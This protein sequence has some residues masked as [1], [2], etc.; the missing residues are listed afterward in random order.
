MK[1]SKAASESLSLLYI[2]IK[3]NLSTLG[4]S[5]TNAIVLPRTNFAKVKTRRMLQLT[6]F[7]L[8]CL[9]RWMMIGAITVRATV[10]GQIMSSCNNE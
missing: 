4:G 7:K 10:T 1:Y 3:H 9:L 2:Y 5:L 6:W 8:G